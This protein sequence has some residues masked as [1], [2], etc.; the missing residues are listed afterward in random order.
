MLIQAI[1]ARASP[2]AINVA[3]TWD[4]DLIYA[5]GR[6]MGQEFRG[7]GVNVA[8]G[9]MTNLARAPEGGRNWEVRGCGRGV[10]GAS[11]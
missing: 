4:A 11:R 2:A 6:A 7:K 1:R 8:L 9:P 5:R 3:A 10:S